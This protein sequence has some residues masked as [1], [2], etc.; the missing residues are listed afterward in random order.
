MRGGAALPG[1]CNGGPSGHRTSR[2]RA[3]F[4]IKEAACGVG[5]DG[6]RD[7]RGHVWGIALQGW[8]RPLRVC[9]SG[10]PQGQARRGYLAL[11]AFSAP[12]CAFSDVTI[13][14][15]G[16]FY[17]LHPADAPC[18][19]VPVLEIRFRNQ[20]GES[21]SG[22]SDSFSPRARA[23]ASYLL[24]A[25]SIALATQGCGTTGGASAPLARAF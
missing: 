5:K 2:I 19:I 14:F 6:Q 25:S 23:S 17:P 18:E 21:G 16:W 7:T 9:A 4:R 10:C 24:R 20:D 1:D 8:R 13:R 12:W 15:M 11:P 22:F 3:E